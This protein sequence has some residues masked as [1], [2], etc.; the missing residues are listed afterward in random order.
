MQQ[1]KPSAATFT[2]D[3]HIWQVV[4]ACAPAERQKLQLKSLWVHERFS[5]FYAE[6]TRPVEAERLERKHLTGKLPVWIYTASIN[7]RERIMLGS[8]KWP[9]LRCPWARQVT[10]RW[11]EAGS[12]YLGS[13][14]G[15][16]IKVKQVYRPSSRQMFGKCLEWNLCVTFYLLLEWCKQQNPKSK[17]ILTK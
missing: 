6:D 4:I 9:L 15:L 12:E 5:F 13:M 16:R 14:Q 10:D 17:L 3:R 7:R 2:H 8:S 11:R 1:T